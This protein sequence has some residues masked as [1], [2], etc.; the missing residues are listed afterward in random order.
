MVRSSHPLMQPG[1]RKPCGR[2]IS[3]PEAIAQISEAIECYQ[4]RIHALQAELD[5]LQEEQ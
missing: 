5:I 4:G 2:L 1:E 3:R